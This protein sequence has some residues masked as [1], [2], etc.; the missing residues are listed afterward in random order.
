MSMAMEIFTMGLIHRTFDSRR[1]LLLTFVFCAAGH[2]ASGQGISFSY[3]VP[4]KGYLSAPISPFSIRGVGYYFGPVGIETGGSVYAMNG[5]EMDKLP[6]EAERPLAGPHFSLL[7]PVELAFKLESK[8]VTWKVRGGAAGIWHLNP[9]LS[10]GNF[11][12]ALR[13]YE[14]WDVANANATMDASLG[15]GWIV[16]TSFEWH[17]SR[18]FSFST[19]FSYLSVPANAALS[20]SY[21]GGSQGGQLETR[22]ID[23]SDARINLEGLEVSVGVT[24][25]R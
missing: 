12:R 7:V 3:L 22:T 16:G 2:L 23:F 20:G 11:D 19:E 21:I 14:G 17:I 6:F 18:E 1:M 4:N 15:L 25:R 10:E 9:R 13:E 8:I 5:L 24:I